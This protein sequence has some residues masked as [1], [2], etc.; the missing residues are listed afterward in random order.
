MTA[1]VVH[2]EEIDDIMSDEWS[3]ESLYI[4]V[5]LLI[6]RDISELSAAHISATPVKYVPL[7]MV[8]LGGSRLRLADI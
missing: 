2:R 4:V 1:N 3:I 5:Y 7:K 6:N 8:D